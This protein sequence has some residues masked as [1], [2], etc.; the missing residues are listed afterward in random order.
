VDPVLEHV[1]IAHPGLS[2][3][4]VKSGTLTLYRGADPTCTPQVVDAG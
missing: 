2:I 4:L 1:D 3:V